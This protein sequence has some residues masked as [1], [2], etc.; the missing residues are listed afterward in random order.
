M[1]WINGDILCKVSVRRLGAEGPDAGSCDRHRIRYT[2]C[3]PIAPPT[4]TQAHVADCAEQRLRH[5]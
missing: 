1:Q 3:S 2:R 4:A 5:Q